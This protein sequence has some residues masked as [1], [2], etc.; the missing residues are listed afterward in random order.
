MNQKLQA[1]RGQQ[2]QQG[3]TLIELSVVV[4]I[5]ALIVAGA[6]ISFRQVQR[7]QTVT[8]AAALSANLVSAIARISGAVGPAGSGLLNC[9]TSSCP[10]SDTATALITDALGDSRLATAAQG[11]TAAAGAGATRSTGSSAGFASANPWGGDV[12]LFSFNT[13]SI[14]IRHDSVPSYA[15]APLVNALDLGA[16]AIASNAAEQNTMATSGGLNY[17]ATA[18]YQAATYAPP[19]DS[20]TLSAVDALYSF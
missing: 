4:V 19:G 7:S 8:A 1:L 13:R 5:I 20:A 16:A 9:G 15:V 6:L 14:V 11:F 17:L 18:Q 2:Q 12:V 3:A 10:V